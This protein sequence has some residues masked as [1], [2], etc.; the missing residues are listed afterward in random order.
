MAVETSREAPPAM[1]PWHL[2]IG[3]CCRVYDVR[4][5]CC[6]AEIDQAAQHWICRSLLLFM[7]KFE[8]NSAACGAVQEGAQKA[9]RTG[10]KPIL[11]TR[12]AR[13]CGRL[14]AWGKGSLPQF[15]NLSRL[16]LMAGLCR[17]TFK[18]PMQQQLVYFTQRLCLVHGI[19]KESSRLWPPRIVVG[20][21]GTCCA[22]AQHHNHSKQQ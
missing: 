21:A 11:E 10:K 8:I 4:V 3:S 16:S 2:G 12:S 1:H 19:G 22:V 9:E 14:V 5:S 17:T 18:K 20:G 6:E 13:G 7:P 15:R